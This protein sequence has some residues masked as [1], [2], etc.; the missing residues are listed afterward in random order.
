M[1]AILIAAALWAVVILATLAL[2]RMAA[3]S[4]NPPEDRP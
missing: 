2:C 4:D 1:T 3:Q